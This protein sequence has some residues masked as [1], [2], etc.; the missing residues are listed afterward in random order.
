MPQQHRV[1]RRTQPSTYSGGHHGNHHRRNNTHAFFNKS[2]M[3]GIERSNFDDNLVL[4]MITSQ[5]LDGLR[6]SPD[7]DNLF[8]NEDPRSQ[9]KMKM[10]HSVSQNK[11]PATDNFFKSFIYSDGLMNLRS[12]FASN[13]GGRTAE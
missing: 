1:H 11:N 6:L 2:P 12:S 10:T 5:E 9:N 4:P 13:D 8:S 3:Y 7:D